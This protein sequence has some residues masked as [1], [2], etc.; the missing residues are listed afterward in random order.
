LLGLAPAVT[1][2][3][4]R[5]IIGAILRSSPDTVIYAQSL[6]PSRTPKFNRWSEEANR[7]IRNLTDGKSVIFVNLRPAFYDANHLLDKRYTFDGI[8]LSTEGY[9][10]W[11]QQIDPIIEPLA[12]STS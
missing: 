7:G 8:H 10:H 1:L 3:N 2:R 4:Y 5:A 9:L 12:K 6:L 11:K